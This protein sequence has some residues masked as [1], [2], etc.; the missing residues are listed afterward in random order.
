MIGWH[1]PALQ[2]RATCRAA[3][4]RWHASDRSPD[5]PETHEDPNE[6]QGKCDQENRAIELNRPIYRPQI[7]ILRHPSHSALGRY[8]MPLRTR[9]EY[10][11]YKPAYM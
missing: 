10:D 1:A 7:A 11:F 5:P 2:C 9:S 8:P 6:A 3:L 4:A